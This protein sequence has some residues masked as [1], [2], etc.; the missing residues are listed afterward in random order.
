MLLYR[1]LDYYIR[2][3]LHIYKDYFNSFL[4]L[5]TLLVIMIITQVVPQVQN[6]Y[7]GQLFRP[8]SIMRLKSSN[9]SFQKFFLNPLIILPKNLLTNIHANL[10]IRTK[11]NYIQLQIT[12]LNRHETLSTAKI[13]S[14][15]K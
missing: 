7:G 8:K 5:Y 6:N 1:F 15:N 13:F 12:T 11:E 9:Y 4:T 2:W 3:P 10:L 14:R